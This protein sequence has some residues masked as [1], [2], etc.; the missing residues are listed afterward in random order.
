[1]STILLNKQVEKL[2]VN[3]LHMMNQLRGIANITLQYV[4][5]LALKISTDLLAGFYTLVTLTNS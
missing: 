4:I 5:L 1:M 3:Q 2:T